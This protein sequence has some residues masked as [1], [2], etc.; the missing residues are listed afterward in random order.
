MKI[1]V[2][3]DVDPLG[4]LQLNLLALDFALTPEHVAHIRRT[5]PRPFPFFAIYAVEGERVIGQ[6]GVFR[7]PMLSAQGRQDVGGVWAVSTHPGYAGQGVASA[8]LD[9]AHRRMCDAGLLF[10]T[11]GTSRFRTAYRLYIQHGYEDAGVLASAMAR[12]ETAHQP[13]RLSARPAGPQGFD[14]VERMFADI[15]GGYLGFA[16]RH[17]PFQPLRDK[18]S[19]QDLWLLYQDGSSVGYAIAHLEKD[20][21]DISTVLLDAGIDLA[22]AVSA[23][24]SR[25]KSRYV[26]VNAVRPAEIASLHS[27]GY[28]VAQPSWSAFMLK[29]L[30]PG[31]SVQEARRLF[32][33]GTDRFL[34]SW[35]DT[36]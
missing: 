31:A 26:Q 35:L 16:W 23:L 29:P 2:Y 6:V 7:L 22:E 32:G 36:T 27:A 4:V 34:I 25:L 5:D 14:L 8:L 17:T 15:A 28:Q 18:V 21:L 13:T 30:A 20:I 19:P 10:S 24:A 1:L 12:W 3:D 33:I 9:E 11:L